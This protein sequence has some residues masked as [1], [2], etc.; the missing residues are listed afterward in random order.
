[1][2]GAVILP[3]ATEADEMENAQNYDIKQAERCSAAISIVKMW[4]QG[5]NI[6]PRS[7]NLKK[8]P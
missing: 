2:R 8:F 4:S 1:M 3:V 5:M 6:P 7:K